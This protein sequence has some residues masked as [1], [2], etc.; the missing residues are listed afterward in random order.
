[1]GEQQFSPR[2]ILYQIFAIQ[3]VF[4]FFYFSSSLLIGVLF[5]IPLSL[6][7][8]FTTCT[9]SPDDPASGTLALTC[10]LS[11]GLIAFLLPRLIERT[12][13]CLDFVLTLVFIHLVITWVVGGFPDL[14]VWWGVWGGGGV[15][16]TL[17]GEYLCMR[18]E[19]KEISIAT[20]SD[21]AAVELG[22]K[23]IVG[24]E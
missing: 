15:A 13:K 3:T 11:L 20:S 8:I 4:Y 1:M 19:L 18:E 22:R 5:G 7:S 21:P 10:W 14:L 23:D 9:Y 17:L 24:N 6:R 12:R 16:C 2:V